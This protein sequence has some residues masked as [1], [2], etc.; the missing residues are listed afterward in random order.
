M[1]VTTQGVFNSRTGGI[2]ADV[3]PGKDPVPTAVSAPTKYAVIANKKIAYRSI[4]A[5]KPII[6]CN[7]FRGILDSWD[8]AFLDALAKEFRVIIFDYSGIGLSSGSLSTEI[9]TVANDVKDLAAFL[10]LKKFII[11][12]W[13]Y[14]GIVAQTFSTHYPDAIT[15]TVVIGT[16]PPGKNEHPPE[17][18][19]LERS[20]KPVNDFDDEIILFFE[21]AS[22][23]SRKAAKRSHDRIAQRVKDR[24]SMVSPEKF[25]LYYKG[26][27]DYIL[28]EFN[29]REKLGKLKTPVLSLSGDHDCVCP[30]ENW[31]PLTRVMK[32]LQ[33]IML[34]Q[35]GH[36]PQHQY[37]EICAK[38]ISSFINHFKLE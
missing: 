16:N 27:A 26:T 23:I 7:R 22:D 4:G 29:S 36:G 10:Q 32:N 15:H 2:S 1:L 9:A 14:G 33:I 12:G 6:L 19:F 38:Y 18:I 25:E 21:P 3:L 31:Y 30:I 11:G 24:D 8:P 17:K 20:S 5:G 34:P 13:S 35:A 37:P 28:D